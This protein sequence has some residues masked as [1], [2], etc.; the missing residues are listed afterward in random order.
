MIVNSRSSG[1]LKRK[2]GSSIGNHLRGHD[3]LLDLLLARKH[4]HCLEHQFLE[5]HSQPSCPD[6]SLAS[7]ACN[8]AKRVVAEAKLDAVPLELFLVLLHESVLGSGQNLDH[9]FL[10]QFMESSD[11]RQTA[12]KFRN[13]AELDEIFRLHLLEQVG[14]P[15]LIHCPQIRLESE[16]L[17][18]H[19][20]LN[21]LLQPDECAAAD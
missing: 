15:G 7:Q 11:H 2:D 21:D 6:L 3:K 9:S 1:F 14:H 17:L 5:D 10:I 18:A 19:P 12:D 13:E 4:V 20:S 16:R 8:R